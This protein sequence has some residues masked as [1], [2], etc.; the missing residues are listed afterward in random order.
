MFYKK[1]YSMRKP[2]RKKI[3]LS[4]FAGYDEN[5]ISR[6][7]PCDYTDCVFNYGFKNNKLVNPYG[8]SEF[9]IGDYK[10]PP[11][12]NIVGKRGVFC[13]T[14]YVNFKSKFT[15]LIS[16]EG[17]VDYCVE[18][19]KEWSHFDLAKPYT[20]GTIFYVKGE[21]CLFVAGASGIQWLASDEFVTALS[22]TVLDVCVHYERMFA[23]VKEAHSSVWFS[24]TGNAMSWTHSIDKGGYI[25]FDGTLGDVNVIKSFNNYLYVFCDY[26][27]YRLTAYGD[28]SQ[29]VLKKIYTA[30]GR[31]YGPS[32][33]VCGEYVAFA[34]ED[35]IFLFDGYDVS[36][37]TTKINNM[38][39]S[40]FDDIYACYLHNK[41]VISFTNNTPTDFGI[42]NRERDNDMLLVFDIIDKS[43]TLMRGVSLKHLC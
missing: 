36:R 17:G 20:S 4:N 10:F 40:G 29:F 26:G 23:V 43:V 32:V 16:H 8:V 5:K 15:V 18:G 19:D 39:S 41:Y 11:L 13:S 2:E 34:G 30:S 14:M 24:A 9:T 21:P 22:K 1:S 42:Y 7:L 28:Q 12:P 37:Y 3:P 27:I 25:D 31:I 33:T 38:I 35:G 6:T